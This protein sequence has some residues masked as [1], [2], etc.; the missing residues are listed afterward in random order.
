MAKAIDAAFMDRVDYKQFVHEPGEKAVYEILRLGVNAFIRCGYIAHVAGPEA[1]D[2]QEIPAF[3][4]LLVND[5]G[6]SA[7]RLAPAQ[8]LY[9]IAEL[10]KQHVSPPPWRASTPVDQEQAISPRTLRKLPQI[11]W[12]MYTDHNECPIGDFLKGLKRAVCDEAL[13]QAGPGQ[14]MS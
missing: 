8:T 1:E 6:L 12:S 9:R 11:A 13:E 2:A 5:Y 14:E 3:E 4:V 7:E 10:C